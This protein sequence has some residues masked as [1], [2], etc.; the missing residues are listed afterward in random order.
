MPQIDSTKPFTLAPAILSAFHAAGYPSAIIA[1]GACRDTILGVPVKDIDVFVNAED[2]L[3]HEPS[4]I[5]AMHFAYGNNMEYHN[6]RVKAEIGCSHSLMTI[7]LAQSHAA[8]SSSGPLANLEDSGP[9]GSISIRQLNQF[10]PF[11]GTSTFYVAGIPVQFI[12]VGC[13]PKTYVTDYM[14]VGLCKAYTED[15]NRIKTTPAFNLDRANKTLSITVDQ[16]G[17]PE[18]FLH[19]TVTSNHL[20]RMRAKY[21]TH[22]VILSP[23]TQANFPTYTIPAAYK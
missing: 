11:I 16:P 9:A 19:D 17:A 1:G 2:L 21:P 8:V 18:S 15:G 12:V 22:R 4:N 10:N 3:K 6:H 5:T 23:S 7:D 13:D 14:D 20:A